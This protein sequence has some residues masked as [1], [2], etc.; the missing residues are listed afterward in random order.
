MLLTSFLCPP[1]VYI[2]SRKM[3][4]L[5]K[6]AA[7][8]NAYRAGCCVP[9]TADLTNKAGCDA[10]A[11]KLTELEPNGLDV[12]VNNSGVSWGS[13]LEDVDEVRGWDRVFAVNVKSIF[14]L[15]VALL[16]LLKKKAKD[17]FHPASVINVTSIIASIP[18]AYMPTAQKGQGAFSYAASKAAAAHL[19]RTM[20]VPL[21]KM[22]VNC[23]ALAPGFFPSS[24][25]E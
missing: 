2:A 20:A 21:K 17:E 16:P 9:I 15:T 22:H 13:P 23:N 25:Y 14:Y 24:E 12:L 4:N 5:D 3:S 19:T 1:S 8:L 11:A 6:A 10:L 7:A 18:M